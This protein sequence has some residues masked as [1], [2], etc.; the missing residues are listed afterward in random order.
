M[1]ISLHRNYTSILN[2]LLDAKAF[3]RKLGKSFGE[4]TKEEFN[5]LI[6]E[7]F[8]NHLYPFANHVEYVATELIKNGESVAHQI[9]KDTIEQVTDLLENLF[10]KAQV[11][12]DALKDLIE[13]TLK[14]IEHLE[15][16][17]FQDANAL[18]DR[19]AEF[20]AG[21]IT[22]LEFEIKKFRHFLP[23]PWDQ[24]KQQL[25]IHWK[26]GLDLSNLEI[27]RLME[28]YELSKLNENKPV[29]KIIETYAQLQHSA[30]LMKYLARGA[31][32]FQNI[33]IKDWFKYGQLCE[34]WH[35]Y[36]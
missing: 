26:S 10:K 21:E 23:A 14:E 28:C 3:G 25:N 31:P 5:H 19:I 24:C 17:F 12:T 36:I 7:L 22:R 1:V 8:D 27:Y 9:I 35:Q 13:S 34:F 20:L 6:D 29:E 2:Y 32:A 11:G 30:V 15:T 18:I 4:A 33:F 16:K